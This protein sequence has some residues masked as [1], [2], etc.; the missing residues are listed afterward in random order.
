VVRGLLEGKSNQEKTS[1]KTIRI[2]TALIISVLCVSSARAEFIDGNKLLADMNGSQMRQM[3]AVG[4]VM[5]VA[6]AL[7]SITI[8]MP[9]T[10]TAGQIHD[11]V[12]NHLESSPQTRHFS[13]DSLVSHVL[14]RVWP[15]RQQQQQRGSNS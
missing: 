10:V 8:C 14:T 1:M 4:Y 2:R 9:P 11:M 13:G 3:A 15:C 5:G 6:D 12:K 7:T